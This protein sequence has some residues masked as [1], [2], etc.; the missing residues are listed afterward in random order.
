M[1]KIYEDLSL[2]IKR[3]KL[4]FIILSIILFL[5]LA[6]YWKIQIWDH[7]KYWKMAEAN[8]LRSLPI[9]APRGLIYDRQKIILADN[10]P[11]FKVSWLKEAIKADHQIIEPVSQ[12]LNLRP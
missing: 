6:F 11:S 7:Q 1:A 3:S 5:V 9:P 12:L 8:H 10:Q 4:T 2:L